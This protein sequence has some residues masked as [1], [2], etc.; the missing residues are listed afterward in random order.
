M[1]EAIAFDTH[2][3]VKNLT[4]NGFTEKQAEALATEQVQ[5]LNSN[6]ATK[7][8]IVAIQARIETVQAE[9]QTTQ[10]RLQARIETSQAELRSDLQ[11][12]KVDLLKWILTAIIA[13]G[14]LVVALIKLL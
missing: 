9:L 13:Q 1:S 10:A 8:D 2:R 7:T 3:F 5:L 12:T 11:T 6:L 4:Q 14:G